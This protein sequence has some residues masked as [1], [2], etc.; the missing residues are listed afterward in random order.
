MMPH[1]DIF[2]AAIDI[3]GQCAK[4]AVFIDDKQ[5]NY[6]AAVTSGMQAI[7]FQSPAQLRNEL[8]KLGIHT[9]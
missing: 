6:E 4:T 3:A 9:K 2:R 5:E 1:T 7:H 8:T